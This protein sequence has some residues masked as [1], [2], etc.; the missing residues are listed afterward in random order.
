MNEG[1]S[2]V[3]P[4][5][6]G[7][8]TIR[9]TL[10]AIAADIGVESQAEIVVVDDASRDESSSILA[11]L[12]ETMPIRVIAGEGRG[13]AAALNA[14][15]RASRFSLIAQVDQDVIIRPGWTQALT[16]ALADP[17]VAAAQGWYVHDP[18]AS[19]CVRAM[20]IDLEERYVAILD[21]DTDHVCTGNT[22]YRAS[23]LHLIGLFDETLGYGYDNDVSYRL[24]EAGYRLRIHPEAQS[25]HRWREGFTGYLRQQY[26][27]GYGRVDLVNKHPWRFIGDRVSPPSMMWHPLIL[28]GALMLILTGGLLAPFAANWRSCVVSGVMFLA[29]LFL[30]R[31]AVGVRAYL[32]VGDPASLLFPVLHLARDVVWVGA[33]G[34]WLWRCVTG[35]PSLPS[36]SMR[37]RAHSG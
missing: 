4:V 1:I 17:A 21:A 18:S 27:F 14:G 3:V 16:E 9:D 5:H 12:A 7:A 13:A 20:A 6:N 15:I 31:F 30:E 36:H 10:T 28:A 37:A 22:V 25:V 23:A 26:G 8:A 2:F 32:R 19:L 24:H 33:I 34:I 35:H 29:L 11:E